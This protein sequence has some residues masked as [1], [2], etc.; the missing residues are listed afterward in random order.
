MFPP[1]S[2]PATPWAD[3]KQRLARFRHDGAA[4][5]NRERVV[6]RV[7][8]IG[9]QRPHLGGRFEPVLGGHAPPFLF[10]HL[11]A[12]RDAEQRVMR[13][14]H[15][16]LG[17]E[18]VVGGDER[19]ARLVGQ[20]DQPRLD[21]AGARQTVPVQLHHGAAGKGLGDA[22]ELPLRLNLPSLAQQP[23]DG[24]ATAACEEDQPGRVPGDNI[25]GQLWPH[26]G[27]GLQKAEGGQALKVGKAGR[28]LRE[29]HH[30]IGRETRTSARPIRSGSR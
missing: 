25:K 11:S 14:E 21:G 27:L 18:A 4:A 28:I 17:E 5:G 3:R 9:E 2:S 24:A 30:L 23:G 1:P 22:P 19:Q 6:T 26:A 13:L 7:R 12:F 20:C 8:Q 10:R 29:Q 15:G 16:G